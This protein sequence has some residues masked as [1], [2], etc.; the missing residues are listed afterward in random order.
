[1]RT[2][3]KGFKWFMTRLGESK[4]TPTGFIPPMD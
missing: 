1:M 2:I 3:K 4:I